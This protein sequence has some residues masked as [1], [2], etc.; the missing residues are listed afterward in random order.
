MASKVDSPRLAGAVRP[1][2][3]DHPVSVRHDHQERAGFRRVVESP[4]ATLWS[5]HWSIR[6]KDEQA[7]TNSLPAHSEVAV[8]GQN[9]I[10]WPHLGWICID[11]YEVPDI[12]VRQK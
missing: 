4:H 3:A 1:A 2:G 8:A 5:A 11:T 9:Q 6:G 10:D 7:G 12:A